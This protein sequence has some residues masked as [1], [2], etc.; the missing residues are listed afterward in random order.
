MLDEIRALMTAKR[1]WDEEIIPG[2]SQYIRVPNVSPAFDDKWQENGHMERAVRLV[3]DL[4]SKNPLSGLDVEIER[5]GVRTPL[6]YMCAPGKRRETVL[7]YGHLDKQ[8]GLSGW[9]QGL[10]AFEPVREGDKLYGRGGADD[11]YAAFASL[12]A[13]RI[14][15]EQGVPYGRCVVLIEAGEES[16]SPDL[17]A[18]VERLSPHIG[19]PSL[20]IC[21]D[22][23][24]GNYDQLWMTNSLRGVVGGVLRVEIL[25]QGVHSG[26]ASGIVP[27][28]FQ[29]LRQLLDRVAS[30][31]TGTIYHEEFLANIPHD[32]FE[33][34]RAVAGALGTGVYDHFPFVPGARPLTNNPFDLILNRTWRSA[35]SVT[36]VDGMPP[37]GNAGN[38]LRPY[39][40][41]KL[42]MRIPPTTDP[43]IAAAKL[44]SVL[45][46]NPPYGARVS[47]EA[48]QLAPGWNAPPFASW[49]EAAFEKAST[50]YFGKPPMFMGEGGSIPFMDMLSK[51]YPEA[52]FMVT[53]LLGPG[54]NAHGANESLDIPAGMKL[55]AS[56]ASVIAAN[57]A[58]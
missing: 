47:F 8:P 43:V 6:I 9:R 37:I 20:I 2:L 10:S 50:A 56:V 35:L 11:G 46:T 14:L 28:S 3:A 12:A 19:D 27:S 41:V 53:G 32:R 30:S 48:D 15:Q 51:R 58:Y 7:M 40:S 18:Y 16:G 24:C 38:V 13:L 5:L 57:A 39:T 34:A 1:I 25:E 26:D 31:Q 17:E 33:Q 52:Q 29:I 44:K 36:G 54:S 42:S 49:L 4:C 55:T 22:S 23:G 45:E 21:L